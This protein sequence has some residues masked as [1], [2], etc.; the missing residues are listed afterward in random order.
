M[1]LKRLSSTFDED[2]QVNLTPLV[3]VVFV[4]LI[5]FMVIAPILNTDH[6]DLAPGGVQT[7]A[8]AVS[9]PLSI[10]L[11]SD[12]TIVF[13]GQTV[14]MK[15]LKALLQAQKTRFP[16]EVPQLLADKKSHFGTYQDI[17]N[18]LEECGFQQ[19][20]IILQ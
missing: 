18:L 12:N 9:T 19:M 17:K 15:N 10:S 11:R 5:T 7:K 4:I 20:D 14:S 3:D 16:S 8:D 6:V 1:R 13:Q 2:P